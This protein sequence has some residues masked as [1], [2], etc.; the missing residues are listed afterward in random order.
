VA[1]RARAL[2]DAA[3]GIF[4]RSLGRIFFRQVEVFGVERIPRDRPLV[5]VANHDNSLVDAVLLAGFLRVRPR[6]LAKSTLWSHPVVAPLVRLFGALPVYRRQDPGS[7]TAQNAGTFVRCHAELARGAAVALFPEGTSHSQPHRLPLKTGAA[8]IAL[9]AEAA[10][11]PLGL[12]ILSVGLVYEAK[13]TFR[14][15]AIVQVGRPLDPSA[16]AA[17]Y[18][19]DPVV[20]VRL[21]TDRIAA[22]LQDVTLDHA[23]EIVRF[24]QARAAHGVGTEDA[25]VPAAGAAD[26]T[27]HGPR[28]WPALVLGAPLAAAGALLN[29]VPYRLIDTLARRATRTPDEPATFKVVAALV[30]FPLAWTVQAAL[31]WSVA[32]PVAAAAVLL[33]APPGGLVALRWRERRERVEE[34]SASRTRSPA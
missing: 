9:E 27:A 31:A 19:A 8:R 13:G 17:L 32:G 10:H 14:S 20:A 24:E 12:R 3:L 18:T 2:A 15:R 21:L 34:V 26:R 6:F 25:W 33:A 11:G 30:L 5:V 29:L 28:A 16:E 4:A 1:A 7:D 23:S 22:A